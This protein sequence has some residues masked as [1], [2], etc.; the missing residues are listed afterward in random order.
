MT[1]ERWRPSA[2]RPW[3]ATRA[4]EDVERY[5]DE[6]LAGWPFRTLRRLPAEEMLWSPPMEMYEKEDRF[7]VRTELPGVN[8][9][10]I[11]ISMM[12]D[13]LVIKGERRVSQGV[14]EEEYHRCEVSYGSFSRSI[15]IPAAVDVNRIEANY[16]DG[17][18]EINLPKAKEAKPSKIQIK[19]KGETK[20]KDQARSKKAS[21]AK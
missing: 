5:M 17:V 20:T 8:Q 1:L 2:L 15:N 14:K 9:D 21:R 7:V 11:D 12:G 13:T 16:E 18:L 19:A 4:L 3:K 10:E 6:V